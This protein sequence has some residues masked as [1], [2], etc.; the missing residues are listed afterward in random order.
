MI[1]GSYANLHISL[2]FLNN[3]SCV[4]YGTYVGLGTEYIP[5]NWQMSSCVTVSRKCM[6]QRAARLDSHQMRCKPWLLNIKI[7]VLPDDISGICTDSSIRSRRRWQRFR[8]NKPRMT[9]SPLMYVWCV[10]DLSV[11]SGERKLKFVY[12]KLGIMKIWKPHTKEKYTNA[13]KLV[14]KYTLP[15]VTI[16]NLIEYMKT[17]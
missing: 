6:I 13:I 1:C 3:L 9:G 2:F 7:L 17:T 5:R 15:G 8:L 16:L 11:G 12:W 4:S 14:T 10:L